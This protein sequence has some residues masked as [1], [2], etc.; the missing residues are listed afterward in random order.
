PQVI[1]CADEASASR[2][3]ADMIVA[4]VN[5]KPSIVLGLATGGTPVKTYANIVADFQAGKVDFR[6][7]TSFN[8]DEYIG[9][10]GTHPQSFR[11]VMQLQLCNHINIIPQKPFVPDGCGDDPAASA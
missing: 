9:L 2:K 6:N 7:A 5:A 10:S 3:V 1:V 11:H 8:L 4:A